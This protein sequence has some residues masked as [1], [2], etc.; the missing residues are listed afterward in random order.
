MA[1]QTSPANY[2]HDLYALLRDLARRTTRT[3]EFDEGFTI[4]TVEMA[5][6]LT[7]STVGKDTFVRFLLDALEEVNL[8][9]AVK[10]DN[11]V[12]IETMVGRLFVRTGPDF[13]N[14]ESE[15]RA[16]FAT[17]LRRFAGLVDVD[18]AK[19]LDFFRSHGAPEIEIPRIEFHGFASVTVH[20]AKDS[21]KYAVD[22]DH[23]LRTLAL[24]LAEQY[25][26]RS[27]MRYKECDHMYRWF[28]DQ[29]LREMPQ[30][31]KRNFNDIFKWVSQEML[32]AGNEVKTARKV[33]DIML[34]GT[35]VHR[36][37]SYTT[38]FGRHI[39]PTLEAEA[40]NRKALYEAVRRFGI[41]IK[42]D[43]A[44]I[45]DFFER[46]S[47]GG[48]TDDGWASCG[49]ASCGE[50][51]CGEASGGEASCGEASSGVWAW[52]SSEDVSGDESTG[53]EAKRKRSIVDLAE[54]VWEQDAPGSTPRAKHAHVAEDSELPLYLRGLAPLQVLA[55]PAVTGA[56]PLYTPSSPAYSP[57]FS[58]VAN[59][60]PSFPLERADAQVTP[61]GPFFGDADEITPDNPAFWAPSSPAYSGQ[62]P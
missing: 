58:G 56:S 21:D 2:D 1:E 9:N 24:V 38:R 54:G 43:L 5:K 37:S 30:M 6:G 7:F 44:E 35:N 20:K 61:R 57:K 15:D 25:V 3:F 39:V 45:D 55:S 46:R 62:T 13:P 14:N 33:R 36:Q 47:I 11:A 49:E 52:A 19:I 34:E 60:A 28:V 23:N 4:R 59:I 29:S 8:Q 18:N 32:V 27:D 17:G 10:K 40:E 41:S 51:S 50:A 16:I 31:K 12:F 42:A 48:V 53:D 22:F 26:E